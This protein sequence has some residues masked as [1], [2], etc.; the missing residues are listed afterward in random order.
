MN[1]AELACG[2]CNVLGWYLDVAVYLGSLAVQA[3]S[4]PGGDVRGQSLPYVPGGN[5]TTRCLHTWMSCFVQVVK[6][7][8]PKISGDQWAE[9]NCGGIAYEVQVANLLCDNLQTCIGAECL[10]LGTEYLAESH[11][12][13]VGGSVVGD[14][15]AA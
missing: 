8:Q 10:Y 12:L 9:C 14:G 4:G 5:E 15:C 2:Y 11:V 3:G 13:Q 7:L 6:Y 1:V